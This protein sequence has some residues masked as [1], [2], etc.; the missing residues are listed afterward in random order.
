MKQ[1]EFKK[2]LE[3]KYVDTPST[4]ANRVSNCKNVEKYYGDLESAYKKEKCNSIIEELQY[5]VEDEREN[6]P[7][8]HLIPIN[9]NIRTGSATLKQ[10]V[11]LYVDF[12]DEDSSTPSIDKFHI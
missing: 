12:R 8:R 5:S 7:Q 9:G 3:D 4:V 1:E 6:N 10:A 2:W 11:N